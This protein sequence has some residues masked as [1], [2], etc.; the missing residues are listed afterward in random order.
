MKKTWKHLSYLT[1]LFLFSKNISAQEQVNW[2]PIDRQ[3]KTKWS[4]NIDIQ[5]VLSEYPR[6][7]MVRYNNW[8]NLNG[9]WE[10]AITEKEES[11]PKNYQGNILVP[12][13]VESAMSG[14]QKEVGKEK[15]L[16]YKTTLKNARKRNQLTL[17]HFG[18]VD[19]ETEV[20][21]NGQKVGEHQ[22]GFDPFTFDI[23]PYL[24][25]NQ[26]ELVVKVWDPTDNGPQPRGK[27]VS[28]PEGIWYTPVTG[29]WQT[30]WI[31]FVPETYIKSTRHTPNINE[32]TLEIEVTVEN[33]RSGDEIKVSAW[34]GKEKITQ[35]NLAEGK[36]TLKIPDCK[37]WSPDNPFLY[38]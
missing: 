8:K 15:L 21:I 27:Q 28:K 38:A 23:T 11:S 3:I 12:F 14:V 7:N 36:G 2:K 6:P 9:L 37:Y 22:G 5:N 33:L 17:L 18:A 16:W 29:I 34:D 35:I 20:Y 26:Q 19:W 31:E 1:I 25:G 32:Q 10:Y 13:P 30:V 4:E 24:K